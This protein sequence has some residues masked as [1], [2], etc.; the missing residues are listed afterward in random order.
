MNEDLYSEE[1]EKEI[2]EALIFA[3]KHGR[4]KINEWRNFIDYD[5]IPLI[6]KFRK[7]QE[8]AP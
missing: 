2:K 4:V 7:E 5:I 1:T 3:E 6:K 8:T